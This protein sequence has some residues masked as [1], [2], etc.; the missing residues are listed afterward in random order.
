MSWR[1]RVVARLQQAK[2]YPSAAEANRDQGTATLSF[3]VDRNGRVL[4]RSIARSSGHASL[5][6]EVL[7]LVQRAQPLPA[8]PPAMTQQVIHLT[9]PIRFSLR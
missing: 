8:F 9:V 4:S 1:D 2:R 5:D 6:Q 7:A 3:S